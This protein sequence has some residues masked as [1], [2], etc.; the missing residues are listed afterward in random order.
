MPNIILSEGSEKLGAL[1]GKI[2]A[3]I[4]SYLQK[5]CI[6]DSAKGVGRETGARVQIPPSPPKQT[7]RNQNGFEGFLSLFELWPVL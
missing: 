4:A 6:R 3:P 7:P 2:Q 5:M 1:Y